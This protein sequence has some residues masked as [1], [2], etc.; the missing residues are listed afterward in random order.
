MTPEEAFTG[1]FTGRKPDVSRLQ[2]FG[3][4]C[5]MLQQDGKRNKLQPKSRQFRF[6][7][8]T[9]ESCAWRYY[10]PI[11]K[12]IL[13]P[14]NIIFVDESELDKKIPAHPPFLE[15]ES[16]GKDKQASDEPP[17]S[18]DSEESENSENPVEV[19]P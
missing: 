13:A 18:G 11:T 15:G 16:S 2:E 10:N 4:S 17:K 12:Q 19:T 7:G 1:S 6:V 14:R 8:L 9:D 3:Q 5:W